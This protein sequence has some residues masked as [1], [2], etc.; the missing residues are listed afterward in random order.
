MQIQRLH[1]KHAELQE[2]LSRNPFQRP[3]HLDS[4]EHS[5]SVEGDIYARIDHPFVTVASALSK[6]ADWCD[7]MLLHL[8]TKYCRASSDGRGSIIHANIGRKFD[9]P[10]ENTHRLDFV[11]RVTTSS[12]A[13]L[14]ITL[15][16]G[17]GPLSTHDYRIRLE[18]VPLNDGQTF[19]HMSYSY[20]YGL[21]GQLAML[22][23]LSTLGRSKV[24]FTVTGTRAD[25]QSEYVGGMR[26]AVERNTMRYYLAIETFLDT[27]PAPPQQRMEKCFRDWFSATE[28]YPRQLHEMEEKDYLAM[29][30]KEYVRQ[31][32]GL[33]AALPD[34]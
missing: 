10:L 26:G 11:F 29:K 9:Q 25:G 33:A 15:N 27:L 16:A 12:P 3:V 18:A 17:E 22:G 34:K 4:N 2:E 31:Q 21:T 13:Y 28:R 6:P 19:M 20:A 24:G 8:N 1:S 14:E 7:I 23:Y 5:G 32:A 30:H